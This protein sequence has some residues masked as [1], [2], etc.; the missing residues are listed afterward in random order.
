MYV[1]TLILHLLIVFTGTCE[2]ERFHRI[3]AQSVTSQRHNYLP[4]W[5]YVSSVIKD[6]TSITSTSSYKNNTDFHY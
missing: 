4:N 2:D 1:Y 6:D 3:P 5:S